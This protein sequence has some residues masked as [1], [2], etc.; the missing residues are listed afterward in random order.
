MC[1]EIVDSSRETS[2]QDVKMRKLW[3][4]EGVRIVN[5]WLVHLLLP[6]NQY[7]HTKVEL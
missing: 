1:S 4:Q 3:N 2:C 6:F 7:D 5:K